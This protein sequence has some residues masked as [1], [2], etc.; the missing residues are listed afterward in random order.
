MAKFDPD[1]YLAKEQKKKDFDPDAYLKKTAPET[2]LETFGRSAASLADSA[3]NTVTGTLDMAAYPLARAYYGTVG[4]M[5]SEQAAAKASEETT[6][7]KDVIGRMTGTAGTKGYETAP[8]R[9]AG[10]YI[11]EGIQENVVAPV[12]QTTGLPEADIGNMVGIGTIAAGPMVPKVAGAVGRGTVNTVRG[13][14]DVGQGV[15]SGFSGDVARPGV[16]PKPGQ[17]ASA[18]QPIGETYIPQQELARWRAGQVATPEL[19]TRPTSELPQKALARTGG[20]VPFE[21]QGFRAFGEQLGQDYRNPYKLG[22]EIAG[23]YLLS[24]VPTVARLGMKGYQGI[25]GARAVNELSKYGFTPLTAAEQAALKSGKPYPGSPTSGPVNPSSIPPAPPPPAAMPMN[26]PVSPAAVAQQMAVEKITP[27]STPLQAAAQETV[28]Q[29][30]QRIMGDKYRAPVAEPPVAAP[31]AQPPIITPEPPIITPVPQPPVNTPAPKGPEIKL[32]NT[33]SKE[34]INYN[35]LLNDVEGIAEEAVRDTKTGKIIAQRT[36]DVENKTITD[37]RGEPAVSPDIYKALPKKYEWE[38]SVEHWTP[39][40]SD[41]AFTEYYTKTNKNAPAYKYVEQA[42]G[43][44]E[45][46]KKENNNW[47]IIDTKTP[48]GVLNATDGRAAVQAAIDSGIKTTIKYKTSKGI[49]TDNVNQSISSKFDPDV[50]LTR[51]I[52]NP[53]NTIVMYGKQNS[54]GKPVKVILTQGLETDFIKVYDNTNS[55]S[56]VIISTYNNKGVKTSTPKKGK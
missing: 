17:Q 16:R 50:K 25:Q 19:Q 44:Y 30:A 34:K 49:V 48:T 7:P 56:P 28:I 55:K 20:T 18:R 33:L 27:P 37:P 10:S 36:F 47:S 52:D 8:A 54:T 35:D 1:A 13:A 31:L 15:Y 45:L 38:K 2:A 5:S 39:D 29:K 46:Y 43:A 22:A 21:G 3:L 26:A 51:M 40:G 4:G 41:V 32:P 11:G 42:S 9:A 24:G 6:S 12:A 23:D 14:V 53:D